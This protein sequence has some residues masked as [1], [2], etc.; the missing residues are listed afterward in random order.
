MNKK[1]TCF[2][3]ISNFGNQN[4]EQSGQ[5]TNPST[6]SAVSQHWGAAHVGSLKFQTGAAEMRRYLFDIFLVKI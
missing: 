3:A 5:R 2:S 6:A 1:R 4:V